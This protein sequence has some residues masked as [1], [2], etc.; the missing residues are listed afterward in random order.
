MEQCKNQYGTF[1]SDYWKDD[2]WVDLLRVDQ[3]LVELVKCLNAYF[4]NHEED[5]LICKADSSGMFSIALAF[6]NSFEDHDEP[7]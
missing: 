4:L 2:L 1:V 3:N 7:C 5:V 6:G